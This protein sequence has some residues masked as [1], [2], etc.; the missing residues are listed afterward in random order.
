[1]FNKLDD[2]ILHKIITLEL[3]KLKNRLLGKYYLIDI[4]KTVNEEIFTR[5]KEQEYGARPIKRIIQNFCEDFISEEILKKN[6]NKNTKYKLKVKNN[7][8]I[9]S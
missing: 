6:I 8:L 9:L 4:D 5:N 1:V 3:S 7:E 2:T